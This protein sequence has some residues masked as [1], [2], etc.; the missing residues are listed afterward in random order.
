[1]KNLKLFT[2]T[3]L[4]IL[5]SSAIAAEK[6]I[7]AKTPN[8]YQL[9][10]IAS[11]DS[12]TSKSE[13]SGKVTIELSSGSKGRVYLVDAETGKL[14]A[15]VILAIK[16][17]GKFYTWNKAKKEKRCKG[18]ARAIYGAKVKG[19][20]LNIGVLKVKAS[21]GFAYTTKAL[22]AGE[23][24]KAATGTVNNQCVPTGNAATLGLGTP[25][26]QAIRKR[27]GISIKAEGDDPDSDGLPSIVDV[28]DDNDGIQDGYDSDKSFTNPPSGEVAT[29][30]RVFSNI[31][32]EIQS[33]LNAYVQTLTDDAV[34]ALVRNSNLAIQVAGG[35]TL[36][37]E[38][39]CGALSYC[40]SGG[41]GTS[42]A[43]PFPD[44]FD[45]DSDGKGT[46]TPGGTGDFQLTTN[47]N[48]D[49]IGAGDLLIQEVD[50]G[51]GTTTSITA[52]LNFIFNTTPAVASLTMG[53][54]TVTP[55]YPAVDNMLG[56]LNNCW[57]APSGWDKKLVVTAFRPQRP[58]ITGAGEGSLV[59]VG[60]S[61]I[62]I[63]IPNSPCSALNSG[64]C[65]GQNSARC[66]LDSYT[67][68][69]DNLERE[70]EGLKDLRGDQ[71][72]DTDNPDGNQITFTV[73]L[74]TCLSETW[75]SGEKLP[76]DLQFS[77]DVGDNAA[78]K[79]C[80]KLP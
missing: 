41:T 31:K 67:E 62:S 64:G 60:N 72:T 14:A 65:S 18:S 24:D 39:D 43:Q 29:E 1:M 61:R 35:S 66:S 21:S 19:A 49:Q 8:G 6:E 36:A 77:N 71:D 59:D 50:N 48:K 22:K 69:D 76:I 58:G 38:M 15:N 53:A 28:D 63:D 42:N 37:T 55:V 70:G 23:M 16:S 30:L 7:A 3:A 51:D 44:S 73:D 2:L 75:D 33:S 78:Q 27:K 9:L 20:S 54:T 45:S 17:G 46:I 32:P 79:F 74:S 26:A 80:I 4:V 56:S 68:S 52:M 25:D 12:G 40:S 57:E 47:A 10:G 13:E 11:D 34:N 5:Q